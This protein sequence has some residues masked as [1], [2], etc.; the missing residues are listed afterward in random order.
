MRSILAL[1]PAL[2]GLFG[3]VTAAAAQSPVAVV[4]DVKGKIPGVEF[5]DY[6]TAGQVIKLGAKDSIV[7][8]Y[9]KSCWRETITG[10][11]VVVGTEQSLVHQGEIARAKADCDAGRLSDRQASESAATVFRSLTPAQQAATPPQ[12]T[13][14]GTAPVFAIKDTG[15]LVV[16]RLDKRDERIEVTP[17]GTA[18]IRGR[19]YD[20]AKAGKALAPGGTYV[21]TSGTLSVVFKIDPQAKPGSAPII[22]RLLRLE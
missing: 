2:A 9:M 18:L 17:R 1:A 16:E 11:T 5:M 21:A 6:V 4:E 7:L 10:G 8:G 22:S 14:Y 15:K 13:L 12:I 3:L 19:F 20:F